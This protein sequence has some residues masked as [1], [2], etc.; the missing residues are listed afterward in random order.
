MALV[1]CKECGAQVAESAPAC[2]QGGVANPGRRVGRLSIFRSS[3][4]TGRGYAVQVFVGGSLAGEIR[5]GAT[6]HLELA[7]GQH[8]VRVK[9]GGLSREASVRIE[10]GKATKYIAFFSNWG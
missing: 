6:L 10:D 3:A 2:P 1:Q 4:M 8:R 7:A 9:G 5:D